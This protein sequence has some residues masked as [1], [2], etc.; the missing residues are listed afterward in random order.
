MMIVVFFYPLTKL[1]IN[2]L[3]YYLYH[4][5]DKDDIS[6]DIFSKKMQEKLTSNTEDNTSENI[7][8]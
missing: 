3:Q 2:H 6:Y 4:A 1:R 7:N 5:D 8:I